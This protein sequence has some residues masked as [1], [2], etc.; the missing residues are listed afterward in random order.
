MAA[1]IVAYDLKQLGQKYACISKKL[2]AYPKY[3]HMQ[4]SVWI[5]E[6][7][8]TAA[9]IKSDLAGCLDSNDN[10]FVGRL[11]GYSAW[12]GFSGEGDIWLKALLEAQLKLT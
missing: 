4:G 12:Q 2:E 8:K 6:T 9:E 1:Y 5:V 7:S 11:Q 10:L 3:W